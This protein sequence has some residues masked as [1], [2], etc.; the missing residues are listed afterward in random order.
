[1]DAAIMIT[2]HE[3]RHRTR[4]VRSFEPVRAVWANEARLEQVVINLLMNARQAL[5]EA[6]SETNE[7]RV[8]VREDGKGRAVLEVCDNGD[9]MPADVQLRIFDPFFT[10]KP[11][12][13][14][15]GL[16]LSIC[17]GIVTSLGGQIR[18]DSEPGVGTTFR[19]VLPTTDLR[20]D[21]SA[22]ATSRPPCSNGPRAHVLVVDDEA[23]IANTMRE[24]LG[25]EHEVV[26]ATGGREALAVIRSGAHFD[27][28][29]CDLMM[30]GMSGIDLYEQLRSQTPGLE[31]KLVFMTGG[32]FTARATEFLASIE[33]RRIEK[34]FS[35][36]MLERIV[37]EMAAPSA[38]E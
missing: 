13:V 35:L 27:V 5:P 33:N 22:T 37:H 10:T 25:F 38:A 2:G 9:G 29:F 16:G 28:I 30:P 17:H 19:V 21:E 20:E 12:G 14:G 4:L 32:A 18:V 26:I 11:V 31:R 15:T 1:V 24:V 23:Q 34:P 36:G 7:I 8:I 3:I 6:R